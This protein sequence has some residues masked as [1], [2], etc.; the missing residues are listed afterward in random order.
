MRPCREQE[1]RD[2]LEDLGLITEHPAPTP[3]F[4]QIAH[5]SHYAEFS[6]FPEPCL[7]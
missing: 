1:A 6:A 7:N 2:A 4:G 5:S 3:N